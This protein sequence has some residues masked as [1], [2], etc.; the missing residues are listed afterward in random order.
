[1]NLE[2]RFFY[3]LVKV[4]H[5]FMH[6]IFILIAAMFLYSLFPDG[7]IPDN[8]RT[9]IICDNGKTSVPLNKAHIDIYQYSKELS[10]SDDEKAKNFCTSDSNGKITDPIM[11]DILNKKLPD[12]T[13]L[14]KN[15]RLKIFYEP[16]DW[17]GYGHTILWFAFIYAVFYTITNLI[18]ESLI[19]VAFGRKFTWIWLKV[20]ITNTRKIYDALNKA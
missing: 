13:E 3:R 7:D 11:L 2:D 1:M 17:F 8:T 14:E 6:G 20:I 19:Y 10:S 4:M 15:Y 5:Y 18:K 16:R 9:Y 12:N